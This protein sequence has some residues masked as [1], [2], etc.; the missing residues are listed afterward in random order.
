MSVSNYKVC[1]HC[2]QRTLANTSKCSHCGKSIRSVTKTIGIIVLALISVAVLVEVFSEDQTSSYS[3]ANSQNIM[4]IKLDHTKN[5]IKYPPQQEQFLDEINRSQILFKKVI[6]EIEEFEIKEERDITLR[7]MLPTFQARDWIGSI[8]TIDITSEGGVI[9]SVS[10]PNSVH[11]AT[12][13]NQLS[14][15]FDKTIIPNNSPIYDV[16][17][18]LKIG[19][20]I[21]FSGSFLVNYDGNLYETS[22]TK[23][24]SV[25]NPKF[26]FYFT[27]VRSYLP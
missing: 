3:P 10:M 17:K 23:K 19:D 1:K 11:V 4:P 27:E 18:M 5:E 16:I 13:N 2:N 22:L 7:K 8:E 6:N 12:W 25:L 21:I 26:I 20:N 14:D 9:L 15:L 24:G